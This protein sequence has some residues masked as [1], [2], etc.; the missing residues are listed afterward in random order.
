MI[1]HYRLNYDHLRWNYDFMSN[2]VSEYFFY[3]QVIVG[4]FLNLLFLKY[5]QLSR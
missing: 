5:N 1:I 2:R 3:L 4:F